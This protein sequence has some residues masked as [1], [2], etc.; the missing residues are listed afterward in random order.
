[1]PQQIIFAYIPV[2]HRGYQEFFKKYQG[3]T[4]YLLSRA[5]LMQLPELEYLKKDIRVLD[6]DLAVQAIKSWQIFDD[7]LSVSISDLVDINYSDVQVITTNDDIGRALATQLPSVAPVPTFEAIFLRWD[8]NLMEQQQVPPAGVTMTGDQLAKE[9]MEQAFA[10]AGQSSDWWRHV[11]AALWREGEP[12]LI[13][14]NQHMPVEDQ[15]YKNSDP[16][17]SFTSGVGIE[18]SSS[19][20][21]EAGLIAQAAKRGI[22]LEG[23]SLYV[24][25][26]PCPVCA[27]QVAASGIK[28]LYY[29]KGYA[30]LDGLEILQTAGVEISMVQFDEKQLRELEKLENQG[31]EVEECYIL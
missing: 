4:L 21:A 6:A 15:Q 18:A 2:L 29:A 22:A 25:T 23:A 24:T 17:I 20:H 13:A 19:I 5:E 3:A 28:Q 26:F 31:S 12:L 30:V 16:R 9:I 27:K 8:K 1:M 7:V 11:G 10:A 14:H